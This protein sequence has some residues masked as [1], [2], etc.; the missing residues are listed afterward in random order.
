M[1]DLAFEVIAAEIIPFAAVPTLGFTLAITNQV[2][3]EPISSISLRCQ[4]QIV[5]PQRRYGHEEQ[6]RLQDVFGI[7]GR[8]HETLRSLLW[9]HINIVVPAFDEHI[10]VTLPVTCTYDFEVVSTK[11]LDALQEGRVPLLFLFSGTIFYQ[12]ER[13]QLQVSR[14]P[15]SKEASYRMPVTLWRDMIGHYY[16]NSAWIRMRK[17]VFDQLYRYKV[18]H[19]QSSW[20]E[21]LT[22]LLA[23]AGQEVQP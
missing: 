12:D 13:H 16:P 23:Q 10:T 9:Q 22:M 14:V 1:P 19:G 7:P 6:E 18:E 2:P 5:A 20:E 8:W 21:T 15:W 3:C 4:L 11:Y 17:D